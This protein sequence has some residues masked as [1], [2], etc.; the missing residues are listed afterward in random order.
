MT[1][2]IDRGEKIK[3]NNIE[4][5]GNDKISKFRLLKSMKKT[6]RK[7]PGRFLKRSKFIESDYN[8][9]LKKLI[10]RL[11]ERGFRDARI[12]SDSLIFDKNGDISLKIDIEEG[13]KYT[14][15]NI[16]FLGNTIYS[17]EQLNQVLKIKKGETYNGV[18]LE[19]RI[20]DTSNPDA[21]D[22]TNLYQNNGYLFSTITPVEVNAD[23]NIIDM[24]IRISE[25]KPAYFKEVS[26]KGNDQTN[27]HVVYRELRTR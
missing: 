18:E 26:V 22:L 4:F 9:D 13:E 16:D 27:D 23:G 14:Y 25:G 1:I 10:D 20:A 24:E 17:D 7:N 21:F 6:K 11:K 19:K 8:E 15:G 12:I 5:S 3:I 2:Y